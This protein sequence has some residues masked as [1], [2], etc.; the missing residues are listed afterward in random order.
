MNDMI[1][2]SARIEPGELGTPYRNVTPAIACCAPS[3]SDVASPKIVAKTDSTS[4]RSP[5]RPQAALPISG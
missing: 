5:V 3:P 2:I 1:T 4:I